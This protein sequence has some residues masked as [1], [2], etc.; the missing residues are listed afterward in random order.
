MDTPSA[1][2]TTILSPAPVPGGIKILLTQEPCSFGCSGGVPESI[3][4][5]DGVAD[6][7]ESL[8]DETEPRLFTG[9]EGFGPRLRDVRFFPPGFILDGGGRAGCRSGDASPM[10]CISMALEEHAMLCPPGIAVGGAGGLLIC[11]KERS[12]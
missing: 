5:A 4:P 7:L 3:P 2:S 12:E 1:M 9:F 8:N 10:P 11:E 6:G